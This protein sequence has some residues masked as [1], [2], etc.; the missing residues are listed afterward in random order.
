MSN[1]LTTDTD[2]TSVANAIRTKGGTNS[3]LSFPSEWIGAINNIPTIFSSDAILVVAVPT[4]STVTAT[5]GNTTLTPT[6]WVQAA[7]NTLDTA[8]FII[9]PA[10][11]D[12][13]NA[14]TV[15]ATDGTDT[16]SKTIVVDSNKEYDLELRYAVFLFHDGV[17]E[18]GIIGERKAGG[19]GTVTLTVVDNL[20]VA[21]NKFSSGTYKADAYYGTN[22]AVDLSSANNIT[23]VVDS[24]T[25]T[26]DNE[27]SGAKIG[28]LSAIPTSRSPWTW[29]ASTDIST[30][31][32]PVT[33]TVDLSNVSDSYYIAIWVG[34]GSGETATINI[35]DWYIGL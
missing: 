5:K 11:F 35:S 15:T 7:D 6:I 8:L 23:L 3:S 20:L 24:A 33:Y 9:P 21:Y 34:T 19:S 4:G 28:I 2:L 12:A 32:T 16:A 10:M 18:S 22:Y 17:L 26:R 27:F 14:W 1:Y 31:N 29:V 25:E 30:S 13:Q